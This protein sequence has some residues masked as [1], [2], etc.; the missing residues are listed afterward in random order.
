MHS[1]H[2]PALTG[3]GSPLESAPSE[4]GSSLLSGLK[5]ACDAVLRSHPEAWTLEQVADAMH[6]LTPAMLRVRATGAAIPWGR[7]LLLADSDGCY[8]LQLDVFSADYRGGL[9]AHGTFGIFWVL[10][11][12]LH[13]WDYAASSARVDGG[14]GGLA[15]ASGEGRESGDALSTSDLTLAR[16]ARIPAG[17]SCCFCPPVS[18]WHRV[19]T[20]AQGPQT[21]SLHLYGPGFDLEVGLGILPTGRAGHYQRSPFRP[22]ADALP[23]LGWLPEG[24]PS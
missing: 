15:H 11:G 19:S 5:Q 23:G 6:V 14:A 12:Q 8:N 20:P 2:A 13:A 16:A 17:G 18:D 9:H 7:Y 24:G 22:L 10:Q 1:P 21:L 4:G 3:S